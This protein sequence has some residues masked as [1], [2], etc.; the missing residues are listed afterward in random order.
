MIGAIAHCL[1]KDVQE[2][3]EKEFEALVAAA[4]QIKWNFGGT[5]VDISA[6]TLRQLLTT[7]R[8]H[9][10]PDSAVVLQDSL[11]ML[12]E[13]KTEDLRKFLAAQLQPITPDRSLFR[14]A[15]AKK[16]GSKS[17]SK[18]RMYQPAPRPAEDI[19]PKLQP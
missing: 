7:L 1:V 4:Q 16:D 5:Q 19:D 10:S 13:S 17:K 11:T 9:R 15:S 12:C 6:A 2:L 3:D 8:I 14:A 18:V